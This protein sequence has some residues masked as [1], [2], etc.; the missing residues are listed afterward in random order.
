MLKIKKFYTLYGK[1][2]VGKTSVLQALQDLGQQVFDLEKLAN[3]RGSVFGKTET[4]QP[5]KNQYETTCIQQIEEF[6]I[7]LPIFSEWKGTNLGILKVPN[8]VIKLMQNGTKIILH[9][10]IT[11]RIKLLAEAYKDTDLKVLYDGLFLLKPRL[12]KEAFNM[13]LAALDQKQLSDFM[14]AM[15]PYYDQ[16]KNYKTESFV[17]TVSLECG[18]ESAKTVAKKIISAV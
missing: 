17:D 12:R 1:T 10:P 16:S 5:S 6:D 9:R 18:K 7:D 13:A 2:G 3:H 11:E 14:L 8:K 15:L 4:N